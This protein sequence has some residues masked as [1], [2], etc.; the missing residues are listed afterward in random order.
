MTPTRAKISGRDHPILSEA[1]FKERIPLFHVAILEV[2]RK[3]P[4]SPVDRWISSIRSRPRH[5]C[6]HNGS[7]SIGIAGI[8][9]E[10]PD[11]DSLRVGAIRLSGDGSR[12]G[13]RSIESRAIVETRVRGNVGHAEA[14]AHHRRLIQLIRRAEA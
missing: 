4:L 7:C 10:L 1:L 5:H 13:L 8:V 9:I 14:A 6:I 3:A 12:V 11:Y 2:G